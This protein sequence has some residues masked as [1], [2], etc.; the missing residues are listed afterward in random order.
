MY[1]VPF[2]VAVLFS[3]AHQISVAAHSHGQKR[4][5]CARPWTEGPRSRTQEGI[6]MQKERNIPSVVEHELHVNVA[7]QDPWLRGEST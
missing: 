4:Q 5:F 6:H 3:S 7:E 2:D 1:A